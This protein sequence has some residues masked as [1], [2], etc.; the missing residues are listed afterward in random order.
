MHTLVAGRLAGLSRRDSLDAWFVFTWMFVGLVSVY[1][2]Y[3][4]VKFHRV[5]LHVEQNPICR[6]LIELDVQQLSWFLLAKGAGTLLVLATLV[7]LYY[8]RPRWAYPIA[9][10]LGAFQLGLLFYLTCWPTA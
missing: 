4:V 6:F 2:A 9:F 8:L 1:D 5:I 10:S 3:L 7:G